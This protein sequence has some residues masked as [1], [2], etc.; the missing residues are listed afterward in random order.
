MAQKRIYEDIKHMRTLLSEA[1]EDNTQTDE[2]QSV[3]Y[4]MQDQVMSSI[5]DTCKNQFGADFSKNKNPMLYFPQDGDVTLSGEIPMLNDAKFQFRYKD[6]SGNGCYVWTSPIQLTDEVV[7][8][9][10]VINGVYKNWKKDMSTTEDIRP[11]G[12]GGSGDQQPEASEE[13]APEMPQEGE[14]PADN[15]GPEKNEGKYRNGD[16]LIL[17]HRMYRRGDDII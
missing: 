9:L 16:D 15:G 14:A 10:H 2:M 17:E 12:Y 7:A 4:S 13:P 1:D 8:A 5:I 11:M 3:P 6:S